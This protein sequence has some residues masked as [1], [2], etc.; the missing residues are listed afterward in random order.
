MKFTFLIENK[1]DNPGIVAE[2]GL[3][4]YIETHGKNI[5]FDAG[6]T[7]LFAVNAEKMGIRL[8]NTDFAVASHGHYDHTGGFPRFCEI[9]ESAPVYI[10]RNGFRESYGL[11]K[12]VIEDVTCGIRWTDGEK[13]M[14]KD[15]IIFTE[16]PVKITD[17]IYITGTVAAAEG[18]KPTENFYYTNEKGELTED[19]MSHE[20]CLVVREPEGLYIFSGCSH[21]GA[22]SALNAAKA[23]F[24]GEKTA[25]FIAGM[26][27]YGASDEDRYYVTEQIAGENIGR[28]LP[29][30][31]TG[32]KAICDLKAK[33]GDR[34]IAA[35]AGDVFY[36]C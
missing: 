9:N 31:C 10:H 6:A 13:S 22:V 5:L 4:V 12:G 35:T 33:L 16:G 11:E 32:I 3:S 23:L 2:H 29:V 18:F 17:D 36:G 26:H 27:L 15:R 20:Q 8:E 28:V 25:A 34:C 24:P 21:R 1:T 14:M 19:D 30:H 7:N